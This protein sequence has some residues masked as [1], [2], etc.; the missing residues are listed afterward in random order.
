[1][2]DSKKQSTGSGVEMKGVWGQNEKDLL[3][4]GVQNNCAGVGIGGLRGRNRSFCPWEGLRKHFT[5]AGAGMEGCH[6]LRPPL[7]L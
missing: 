2:R 3:V 6:H 4:I 5:V 1:M 7:H